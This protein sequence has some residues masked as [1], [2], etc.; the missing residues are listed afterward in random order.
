MYEYVD[1]LVVTVVD[2]GVYH[3]NIFCVRV[4]CGDTWLI[5][6]LDFMPTSPLVGNWFLLLQNWC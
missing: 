5:S 2:G 4:W 6:K 1:V 3:L